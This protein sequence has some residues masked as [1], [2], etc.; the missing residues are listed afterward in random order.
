MP[1][2]GSHIN[3]KYKHD[4]G[5]IN[6]QAAQISIKKGQSERELEGCASYCKGKAALS[7][8]FVFDSFCPGQLA[9]V[10]PI[11]H[12]KDVFVK[13]ATGT[14]KSLCFLLIPLAV[15]PSAVGGVISPLNS[16]MDQQ[17]VPAYFSCLNFYI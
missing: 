14:G 3:I 7:Q 9:A 10:L 11:L 12:G 16:L 15:S 1:V 6:W 8:F 17:V 2:S 4:L 13:M 5:T